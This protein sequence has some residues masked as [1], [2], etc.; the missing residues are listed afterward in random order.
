MTTNNNHVDNRNKVLRELKDAGVRTVRLA[1]SGGNDEGSVYETVFLDADSNP[2]A[3]SLSEN[4]AY[5]CTSYNQATKS[6]DTNWIVTTWDAPSPSG[7]TRVERPATP[8]EISHANDIDTLEAPIYDKFG[9]FAGE[10]YVDGVLV[11]DVVT[12]TY[13][14]SGQETVQSY[15]S[16][17]FENE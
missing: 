15:E 11:W 10:F 3:V 1:F 16:F 6:W 8:D 2:V 13:T 12:G 17:E 7:S 14:L 4:R 5:E 9:S